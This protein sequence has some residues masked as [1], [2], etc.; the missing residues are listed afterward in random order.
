MN[1]VSI[2]SYSSADDDAVA[3]L[4]I[5]RYLVSTSLCHP[6]IAVAYEDLGDGGAD[7]TG[8]FVKS[9]SQDLDGLNVLLAALGAVDVVRHV[10]VTT[11][12]ER[13]SNLDAVASGAGLL[14]AQIRR[15]AGVVVKYV[16]VRLMVP[17]SSARVTT[18]TFF[19][20]MGV[21]NLIAL[22]QDQIGEQA[23][24]LRAEAF[25]SRQR[26]AHLALELATVA[27]L[28]AGM[29]SAPV[30]D[31]KL[32]GAGTPAVRASFVSSAARVILDSSPNMSEVLDV[33]KQLPVP[34]GYQ[35]LPAFSGVEERIAQGVYPNELRYVSRPIDP[36]DV[37]GGQLSL[38]G[39][40]TEIGR[41]PTYAWKPVR[42]DLNAAGREILNNIL[43][44][45][46]F[47]DV[48]IDEDESADQLVT[49]ADIEAII[50]S[51]RK[52]ADKPRPN[53][54]PG[55]YWQN[56]IS[57]L[58]AMFDG[59]EAGEPVRGEISSSTQVLTDQ[60]RIVL[61]SRNVDKVVEALGPQPDPVGEES[62]DEDIAS[63]KLEDDSPENSDTEPAG[64]EPSEEQAAA[65]KKKSKASPK[66]RVS[67]LAIVRF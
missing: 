51:A 27:G 47:E 60:Q 35:N 26:A 11:F 37:R 18:E 31:W 67:S 38:T 43:H 2:I 65:S 22:A 28:W 12:T 7:A 16:D 21:I 30:D 40:V 54:I 39:I 3:G 10:A 56:L 9:D 17:M 1:A 42:D 34:T 57:R 4:D 25:T 20:Q 44:E 14:G 55:E 5:L 32:D 63:S 48:A 59:G 49:S 53:P 15:L 36:V 62:L 41:L 50:Q 61:P 58:L 19:S 46:G 64:D 24:P 45:S 29:N 6:F 13:G 52:E 33:A 23:I 8:L 66:T